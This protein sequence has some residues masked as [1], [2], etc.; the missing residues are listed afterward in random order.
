MSNF[1]CSLTRNTT[2]HST[3]HLAFHSVLWWK[4][5]I[6]PIL[7]S[8]LIHFSLKGWENVLFELGSSAIQ[9]SLSSAHEYLR[10]SATHLCVQFQQHYF[11]YRCTSLG[12]RPPDQTTSARHP[13]PRGAWVACRF[14]CSIWW[15][16]RAHR[17]W[18][19]TGSSRWSRAIRPRSLGRPGHPE[20]L[21]RKPG[22]FVTQVM[23]N[24]TQHHEIRHATSRSTVEAIMCSRPLYSLP[25]A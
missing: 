1:P 25:C 22:N 19:Y 6:L 23:K 24:V 15:P 2:P 9:T 7:T 12:P 5:I 16:A 17:K 18:R 8:T 3:E 21:G 10:L 13:W 14:P 20:G 11:R 4:I